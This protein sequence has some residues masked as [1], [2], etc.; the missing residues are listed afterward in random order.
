M[1]RQPALV[2]IDVLGVKHQWMRSGAEG[3]KSVFSEFHKVIN[4]GLESVKP[5]QILN[6]LVE[7]DSAAILC[8]SSRVAITV[9]R[10][11][12]RAAFRKGNSTQEERLWLRGVIVPY[13]KNIEFRN[14]T[15]FSEAYSSI[16]Y[17][18]YSD[19]LLDVISMEKS[20]FRG[21][22]LLIS[23]EPSKYFWKK[24]SQ[25]KIRES[26]YMSTARRLEENMYPSALL[27]RG[28]KDVLW[29]VSECKEEWDELAELMARRLRLA[30]SNQEEI[31][32]AGVTASVFSIA[33]AMVGGH[34]N[35]FNLSEGDV[36]VV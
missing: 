15:S 11:I 17:F 7:S 32:H 36:S 33:G 19:E 2:F 21:M 35:N 13:P 8:T 9:G 24:P 27:N 23:G 26:G 10:N 28:F 1:D 16:R 20:G 4:T 34:I 18:D 14:E 3:A 25:I 29:M 31:T 5:S 22:R 6:G 12:F 30:A